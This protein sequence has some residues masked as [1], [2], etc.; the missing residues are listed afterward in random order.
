M[1]TVPDIE[2]QYKVK[3]GRI[4]SPGKFQGEPIYTVYFWELYLDGCY[5]EIDDNFIY[6]DLTPEDTYLFYELLGS[7]RLLLHETD[8]G[9]IISTKE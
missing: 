6:F 9:F 2:K 1:L 8:D 3:K 5:D 4:A 7:N